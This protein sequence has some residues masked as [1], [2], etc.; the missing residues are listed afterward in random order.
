MTGFAAA[1]LNV[2]MIQNGELIGLLSWP[3]IN[4]VQNVRKQAL[5]KLPPSWIISGH[6]GEIRFY[7]GIQ[8]I[9]K[10]FAAAATAG[11]QRRRMVDLAINEKELRAKIS[12]DTSDL[13]IAIKKL[14]RLNQ[15]IQELIMLEG[16]GISAAAIISIFSSI[17]Q[18]VVNGGKSIED[19]SGQYAGHTAERGGCA[20]GCP[21]L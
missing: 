16:K 19:Q 17:S 12:V 7:S 10:P 21:D 2:G 5:W 18:G 20:G 8:L 1:P 9:I 11:K 15:L 6:I 13:D 4:F 3:S 14:E